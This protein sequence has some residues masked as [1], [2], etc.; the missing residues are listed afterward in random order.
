MWNRRVGH[1]CS[2]LWRAAEVGGFQS[3]SGLSLSFGILWRGVVGWSSGSLFEAFVGS[4]R[5]PQLGR[6]RLSV[7]TTTAASCTTGGRPERGRSARASMPQA[8]YRARH[9]ITVCRSLRPAGRSRR[10]TALPSPAT[11]S[12][13]AAHARSAPLTSAPEPA[14]EHR[15][16]YEEPA[17]RQQTSPTVLHPS[18]KSLQTRDTR[19]MV[20]RMAGT[21]GCRLHARCA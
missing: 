7:A 1:R 17:A 6:G 19:S 4:V 8:S 16:Q 9:E 15:H 10:S 21:A 5:D 11:R 18:V 3:G 20:W 13:P 12:A 14:D 2:P